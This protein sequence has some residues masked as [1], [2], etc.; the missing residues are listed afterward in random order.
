M[1]A[2]MRRYVARHHVGLVAL[3]IAV[4]GVP[5]AWA[6]ER[7]SVGS[8]HIKPGAVETSDIADDA[9]TSAKVKDGSLEDSDF[10]A[11][12]LPSGP[13]GPQ[14]QQGSQGAT[15][16]Q[17]PAGPVDLCRPGIINPGAVSMTPGQHP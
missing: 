5:M 7:N 11:G 17:G 15:G 2:R 14:G 6:L 9:V 3:C 10:G 4:I 13:T 16:P 8:K 1:S 12:E